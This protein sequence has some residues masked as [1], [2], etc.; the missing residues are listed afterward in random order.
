MLI[1][2]EHTKAERKIL[3]QLQHPFLM[4]LR[5]AFQSQAKLYLVSPLTLIY[6][7]LIT[8]LIMIFSCFCCVSLCLLTFPIVRNYRGTLHN[9]PN[10]PNHP[11]WDLYTAV[12]VLQQITRVTRLSIYKVLDFYQGGELF[13]HLKAMRRFSEQ[14]ARIY[15]GE[16]ALALGYL[17]S[18]GVIYRDLKPENILLDPE[19][20]LHAYV[21]DSAL[22]HVCQKQNIQLCWFYRPC[23]SDRLRTGEGGGRRRTHF[24]FLW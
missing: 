21:F 12:F 8:P 20:R 2:V 1:Q 10:N 19:G 4:T 11:A 14:T 5:Y 7:F 24:V 22:P 18:L 6:F 13:F 23:V 16:I 9:N 15:I 3:Q 17:H